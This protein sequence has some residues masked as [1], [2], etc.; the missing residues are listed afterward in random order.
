M[1]VE[2]VDGNPPLGVGECTVGPT[3]AAV[4]VPSPTRWAWHHDMPLTRE[5]IMAALWT[6]VG[7]EH[8]Y[9]RSAEDLGNV[10]GLEHVNVTVPDQG[11]AT[12]FY[13]SGLGLTRDPYMMT[14]IDNM[15]INVG[16]KSQFH[17]PTGSPQVLRGQV[18]LVI[19]DRA[20]LLSRLGR[21]KELLRNT[22]FGFTEHEDHVEAICP[23]G[24]SCA[25]TSRP[26]LR[27][28][29]AGHA[30]CRLRRADGCGQG[31]AAF[32]RR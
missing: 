11:L 25:A 9:D 24:T 10:V 12:L 14:S 27:P 32:Y 18:G 5:R 6:E 21:V 4:G 22:R 17:L 1:Q 30:L 15:W 7:D 13:V 20:A 2:L 28:H 16:P 23:W 19:P 3:A 29:D 31:I 8:T 26:G